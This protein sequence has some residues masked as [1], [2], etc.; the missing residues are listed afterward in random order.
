VAPGRL[1]DPAVAAFAQ[2]LRTTVAAEGATA[3]VSSSAG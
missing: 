3:A 2:W 1:E